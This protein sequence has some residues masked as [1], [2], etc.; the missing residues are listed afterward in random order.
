M[1][2]TLIVI[3]LALPL[4]S[5]AP[6]P[7]PLP[8]AQIVRPTVQTIVVP[9]QAR[10]ERV[11]LAIQTSAPAVQACTF[12]TAPAKLSAQ[13]EDSIGYPYGVVSAWSCTGDALAVARELQ[14]RAGA[15]Q[16]EAQ[17]YRA[18]HPIGGA[19]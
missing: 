7:S 15:M 19:P 9:R 3:L 18:A 1:I 4:V 16:A 6:A 5:F 8:N 17:A 10:I 2:K 14:T 13:I 12:E 11:H